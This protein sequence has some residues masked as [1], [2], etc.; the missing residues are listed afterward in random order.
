[1]DAVDDAPPMRLQLAAAYFGLGGIAM[2]GS[3]LYYIV[4]LVSGAPVSSNIARYP[5]RILLLLLVTGASWVGTSWSLNRGKR[6]GLLFALLAL[7]STTGR[8]STSGHLATYDIV[9]MVIAG[10]ILLSTWR[11]L[12]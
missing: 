12:E 11:E 10:I 4:R 7:S 8:G 5:V 3:A 6:V 1:M 9:F 2:L